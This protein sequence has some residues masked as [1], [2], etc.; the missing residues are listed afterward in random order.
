MS[1]LDV[2]CIC[3]GLCASHMKTYYF[4]ALGVRKDGFSI[5][6]YKRHGGFFNR[7]KTTGSIRRWRCVYNSCQTHL[8]ALLFTSW[9]VNHRETCQHNLVTRKI[10]SGSTPADTALIVL[11]VIWYDFLCHIFDVLHVLRI[12][13]SQF[14]PVSSGFFALF[15]Y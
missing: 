11:Q 15:E 2:C 4:T 12:S 5:C 3:T 14:W 10:S 7:R 8:G 1:Y 6:I 9:E 13:E